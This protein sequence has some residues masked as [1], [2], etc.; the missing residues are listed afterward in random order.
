[1]MALNSVWM[2]PY[3][4]VYFAYSN[5]NMTRSVESLPF[6]VIRKLTQYL[7]RQSPEHHNWMSFLEH[8][9]K[10]GKILAKS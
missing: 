3:Y 9:E 6:S 2:S 8:A 5:T 10:I 1:M 7:D 4:V